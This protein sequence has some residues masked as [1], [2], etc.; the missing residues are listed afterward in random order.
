[1]G[2]ANCPTCGASNPVGQAFCN[3]CGRALEE[4]GVAQQ[5]QGPA[6]DPRSYTPDHLAQEILVASEALAG[7]RKQ[8][9]V[10]F[11]D[12]MDSMTLAEQCDPEEWRG[13][14][15]RF[16]A[17]LSEAVHRFEGTV[18]KFTGDGMMALFGAPLAR[19]DHAARACHAALHLTDELAGYSAELR[20]ERGLNFLVR[21]GLNTGE[22]VVGGIGDDLAVEYTAIGHTVGLAQRMESLA[23]PGKAYLTQHTAALVEGY[24]ELRDLGDFRIKGA[25]QPVR[26]FEL[27]GLGGLR[28]RLDV[29][30][31]RGFSRFVGR[32]QEM[33]TLESVLARTSKGNA[34][35]I[36]VV[37]DAGIGKSRLCYEFATACRGRGIDVW[38]GHCKAR[39]ASLPLLPL[40]E[41][42]RSYFGITDRDTA[43]AAREK[44]AGRIVLLD[45]S[46]KESLPLLFDLLGLPDPERPVPRIDPG[47]RQRR[48]FRTMNALLSARSDQGPS[49]ILIEDLQWIDPGSEAFL[50]NLVDGLPGTRSLLLLNFRPGF[51]ADWMERSYYQQLSLA[52]LGPEATG[53]LLHDLIGNDPSL[54]G[55]V[56]R[57][58]ERAGG[59]PFFI[60]ELVRR[61]VE[62]GSLSGSRGAYRMIRPIEEAEI[63][64]TVESVLADRIDRLGENEKSVLQAAAV[65]GHELAEPVLRLVVR[66]PEPELQ[67]ALKALLDAEL[68]FERALV[69]EPEYSFRYD[70]T[71][72]VAYHS[73][74]AERRKAL[75]GRVAQAIEQLY[76]DRL[77]ELAAVI[78]HHREEADEKLVSARW[79]ARAAVWVGFASPHE[80]LRHWQKVRDL[81][82]AVPESRE[83]LAMGVSSRIAILNFAWRL[84]A[85]EQE[86]K[87]AFEEG[88][89]LAERS[90][91]R[92]S[93]SV[94]IALD[95]H[96]R[97]MRG[98]AAEYASV[99]LEG[100][101]ELVADENRAVFAASMTPT[102]W[103][104]YEAGRLREVI[105]LTEPAMELWEKDPTLGTG[106][107]LVSPYAQCVM[108]RSAIG[109]VLGTVPL[110]QAV[111]EH[112]RALHLA[113]EQGDAETA[114]WI[115]GQYVFLAS[116][117]GN[118]DLA[119]PHANQ[120]VEISERIGDV[121]SRTHSYLYLGLALRLCNH[122]DEAIAALQR[123][124]K[125]SREAGTALDL[126][127]LTLAYLGEA[128]LGAGQIAQAR[129]VA[130]Q[131]VA[132]ASQRAAP[133]YELV[134]QLSLC[135]VLIGSEDPN[136][137]SE[138]ELALD[139]ATALIKEIGA[140]GIEPLVHEESA[141]L[142]KLAGHRAEHESEL[143]EAQRLFERIGA[144]SQASRIEAELSLVED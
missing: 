44:V 17:I 131:G 76:P 126:E 26:V 87:R 144:T 75:H 95:A 39:G 61:L 1:M 123:S 119:L 3:A 58:R 34:Q 18:D 138:V 88:R 54:E 2:A 143:R 20:R 93:L 63:P 36:G 4:R 59:N 89:E 30:R 106:I 99:M 102:S 7:E 48:L 19:E 96:M 141:R 69:P 24:F 72:E 15:G 82:R 84:G 56:D 107:G 105:E 27:A 92:S 73:Q 124:L 91:D 16:F 111:S 70:L 28:T 14:M 129:E 112:D 115:H 135:R 100:Q 127:P 21:I 31:A 67:Q 29:S 101:R 46:L 55:L 128:Y 77:D 37:G 117:L 60:E 98:E 109:A 22:V 47:A 11:A 8:V 41:L 33:A 142:A 118:A 79:N 86:I 97:V 125:I 62:N 83:T 132:L 64:P 6:P 90:G 133:F 81:T 43:R 23:E 134:A 68:L 113:L 51:H 103:A 25:R 65:I 104:L 49:V 120:S 108:F 114:A 74:L 121:F 12:V 45:E 66:L 5:A 78:G 13:I 116:N 85:E 50:A 9:T 32:D 38:E 42:L 94:L 40:L 10:L 52:P 140:R 80:S 35:V 71:E 136:E 57:I 53:E 122:C 130:R 137:Q 110:T 139:R